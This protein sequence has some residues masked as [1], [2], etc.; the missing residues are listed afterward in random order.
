MTCQIHK[1]LHKVADAGPGNS[2]LLDR[3][4]RRLKQRLGTTTPNTEIERLI[5]A[6]CEVTSSP[7]GPVLRGWF[8]RPGRD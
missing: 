4:V 8:L 5:R 7:S 1:D 3:V 6:G 2:F